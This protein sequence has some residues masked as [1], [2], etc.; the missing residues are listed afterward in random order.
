MALIDKSAFPRDKVCGDA[1]PGRAIKTL[2]Q[3]NP[4]YETAFKGFAHKLDTKKTALCYR[5]RSMTFS[6]V[7][8]AYTCARIHFDDFLFDLVTKNTDTHIITNALPGP[9]SVANS[10]ISFPIKDSEQTIHAKLLI[11]AD[12]AQSPTAKQLAGRT[13]NRHH[14]VGSVRAYYSNVGGMCDD[15]TE[16]YFDKQF[17]PSYLWI[18]PL[19]DNKANVGFGMLS[20]EIAKRKINLRKAFYEFIDR[21]PALKH[22]FSNAQQ[23]SDL[24]GFGL[25]LGSNINTISGD[26]FMLIGDAA[27]LRDPISGDGI[28]NAM[29]SGKLAAQQAAKCFKSSDFTAL[30][31]HEYDATLK[32]AIGKELKT[33]YRAQQILSTYPALLD[34][35]FFAGSNKWLRQL[36]Q[37]GL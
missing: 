17:L 24:E 20:S 28:G 11:G 31:M 18:F 26:R 37:K 29:L 6:W 33:R 32:S 21:N 27:S 5:G 10:T 25:P 36:I 34:I 1:I 12:G 8:Q 16:I 19:P 3:I 4:D 23:V 35:A 14:H 15:T 22:K 7:G 2:R 13:L 30:H 9:L